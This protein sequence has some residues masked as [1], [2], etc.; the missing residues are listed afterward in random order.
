MLPGRVNNPKKSKPLDKQLLENEATRVIG[1][2]SL[3]QEFHVLPRAGGILDQDCYFVFL[4]NHVLL[5]QQARH[6]LD[7]KK[8]VAQQQQKPSLR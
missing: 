5:F 4:L 1:L 7:Q 6:E 8:N 3:V 2:V